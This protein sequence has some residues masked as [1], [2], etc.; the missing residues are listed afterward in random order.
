MCVENVIT[1]QR[2]VTRKRRT[3][4]E[5]QRSDRQMILLQLLDSLLK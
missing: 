4:T 2:E 3:M 5:H 1:S